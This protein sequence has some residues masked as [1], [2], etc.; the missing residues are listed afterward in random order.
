MDR[1]GRG[2]AKAEEEVISV[3]LVG[4]KTFIKPWQVGST[5]DY[6]FQPSKD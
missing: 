5:N 6:Q 1:K 4:G 3:M 2:I